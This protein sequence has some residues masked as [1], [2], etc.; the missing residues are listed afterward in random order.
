MLFVSQVFEQV[1][2]IQERRV[3]VLTAPAIEYL[4]DVKTTRIVVCDFK[5]ITKYNKLTTN[6]LTMPYLL[7]AKIFAM[8]MYWV[9]NQSLSPDIVKG[10]VTIVNII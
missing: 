5:V 1:I 9:Q 10:I 7:L 6:D 2:N 3:D 4:V 8:A